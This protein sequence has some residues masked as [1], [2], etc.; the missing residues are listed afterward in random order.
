MVLAAALAGN[1]GGYRAPRAG[2]IKAAAVAAG[3]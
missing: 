1:V 2:T 3:R